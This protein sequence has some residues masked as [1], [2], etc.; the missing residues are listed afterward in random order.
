MATWVLLRGLAREHAHWERFPEVLARTLPDARIVMLDLPGT[1]ALHRVASPMRVDA[2]ARACRAA[3][4][5]MRLPAPG[6]SGGAGTGAGEDGDEP[7]HLLAMSLGAMVAIEWV[8]QAPDTIGGCVLLNTSVRPFSPAWR[9]LRPHN[10]PALLR[11]G[12]PFDPPRTR[13]AMILG[14]TSCRHAHDD[15][16]QARWASVRLA[17]PVSAANVVRQLFAAATYRAPAVRPGTRFLLLGSRGDRL[18]DP[19]CTEDLARHWQLVPQMHPDAGHDLPLDDGAW[20]AARIAQW[21][22]DERAPGRPASA[23]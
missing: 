12:A 7:I 23:R 1:G 2:I 19:R 14:L 9:R 4:A 3:L 20:V 17:R 22:C 18:V 21:L 5:S 6:G 11:I 15:G 10:W 8:R 16:L 13:E